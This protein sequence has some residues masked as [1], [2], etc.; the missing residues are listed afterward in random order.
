MK[1][2]FNLTYLAFFTTIGLFPD[3]ISLATLTATAI[4]DQPL[5]GMHQAFVDQAPLLFQLEGLFC[6]SFMQD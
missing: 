4:G 1:S 2:S 3:V 6:S 5:I